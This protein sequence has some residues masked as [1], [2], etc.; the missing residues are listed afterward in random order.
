MALKKAWCNALMLA[1]SI[2]LNYIG[3]GN[4]VF[5]DHPFLCAEVSFL[6]VCFTVP[7]SIYISIEY[8]VWTKEDEKLILIG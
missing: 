2:S 1:A 8:L 4:D 7:S 3:G 5:Y 6:C